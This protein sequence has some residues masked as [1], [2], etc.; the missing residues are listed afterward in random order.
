MDYFTVLPADTLLYIVIK[1]D[2]IKSLATLF[3][4]TKVLCH[5]TQL[6]EFTSALSVI[7]R[8]PTFTG[9]KELVEYGM[10]SLEERVIKA[11]RN[12]NI[13]DVRRLI[14][15]ETINI[16]RLFYVSSTLENNTPIIEFIHSKIDVSNL[17]GEDLDDY[18][19]CYIRACGDNHH[20]I[21]QMMFDQ[22]KLN[23]YIMCKMRYETFEYCIRSANKDI[24]ECIVDECYFEH[25]II[26][27]SYKNKG[28]YEIVLNLYH[29]YSNVLKVYELL[30]YI[31]YTLLECT[32]KHYD[33]ILM[34]IVNIIVIQGDYVTMKKIIQLINTRT[35]NKCVFIAMNEYLWSDDDKVINLFIQYITNYKECILYSANNRHSN[36]INIWNKMKLYINVENVLLGLIRSLD[37]NLPVFMIVLDSAKRNSNDFVKLSDELLISSI[38]YQNIAVI[39][40]LIHDQEISKVE[41]I[42]ECII[43][44]NVDI[45]KIILEHSR[46]ELNDKH[47]QL[48]MLCDGMIMHDI[49][50]NFINEQNRKIK[51]RLALQEANVSHDCNLQ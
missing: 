12:N 13:D 15:V 27:C 6:H 50:K 32:L 37:V 28:F 9:L 7:L 8:L 47:L 18:R 48:S 25:D 38:R 22:I 31:P 21:V 33:L 35:L 1:I 45:L 11:I 17:R 44:C 40:I 24:L 16:N 5:K 29:K 26:K 2:D 46:I 42:E 41:I 14:N 20:N 36:F 43:T 51:M 19:K 3:I 34:E 4:T 23:E 39:K 10:L 49:V 30:K